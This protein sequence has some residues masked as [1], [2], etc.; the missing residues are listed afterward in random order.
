MRSWTSSY[1]IRLQLAFLLLVCAPALALADD[2]GDC[3]AASER[4]N[5][6][7]RLLSADS[8]VDRADVC[9]MISP[10]VGFAACEKFVQS[11]A[12]TAS[13]SSWASQVADSLAAVYSKCRV[14]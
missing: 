10:E 6:N 13:Q 5:A 8:A 12:G 2:Y 11:G 7:V 14:Q 3:V 4:Y 1:V 9:R